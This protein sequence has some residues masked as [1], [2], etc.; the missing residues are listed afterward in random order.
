M[1]DKLNCWEYMNCGM[2]PGGIFSKLYG[3]CPIPLKMRFDGINGGRGAGRICWEIM[4]GE[5]RHAN[6]LCRN[7]RQS[8]QN[9]KF[10][11]RVHSE[12]EELIVNSEA[13]I[14]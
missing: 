9:C 14:A 1:C 2:E 5:S 11:L 8:C 10:F 13:E 6:I 4:P 3:P 12:E 7:R